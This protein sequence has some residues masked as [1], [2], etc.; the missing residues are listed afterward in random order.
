MSAINEN[1]LQDQIWELYVIAKTT[2]TAD[3][4]DNLSNSETLRA[5]LD[6]LTFE[7]MASVTDLSMAVNLSDNLVEVEADDT[8]TLKKYTRPAITISWNWFEVWEIDTL[9]VILWIS[10][11][12]VV[13][14]PNSTNYWMNLNTRE[15]P[16]LIIKI[17]TTPDTN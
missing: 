17:V 11:L 1:A 12:D 2:L 16:E 7:R 5:E 4:T 14:T 9:K 6:A 8:W 10:S 15:I 3:L 13:W